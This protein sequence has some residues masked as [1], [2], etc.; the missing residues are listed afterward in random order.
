MQR[1]ADYIRRLLDN[2]DDGADDSSSEVDDLDADP[3]YVVSGEEDSARY[4]NS[5]KPDDENT[6]YK[7]NWKGECQK[8]LE[9]KTW[10]SI[11]LN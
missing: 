11:L 9:V 3:D 8:R 1:I 10:Q 4:I 6:F 2:D 5:S 7:M